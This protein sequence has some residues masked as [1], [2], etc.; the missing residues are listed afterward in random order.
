MN[1][2]ALG[3]VALLCAAPV[4][5]EEA[6]DGAPGNFPV[7]GQVTLLEGKGRAVR[8]ADEGRGAEEALKVGASV[9]VGDHLETASGVRLKVTL[10]DKSVL[11]LDERSLLSID[12]ADFEAQTKE[13][14]GFWANLGFGRVWAR[15]SKAVAGSDAKFEVRT[16]R[17]V[18]GVRGTIF[19]V[20]A[21]TVVKGAKKSQRTRVQVSEGKVLVAS[22]SPVK[23]A[24]AK[25]KPGARVQV[26][27]PTEITKDEWEQRF[28]ELQRGMVV[29]VDEE[30]WTE[31]LEAPEPDH[32]FARFVRKNA[33]E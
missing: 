16:E 15:V 11:M 28:L 23:K 8:R 7:V 20:D 33:Q 2:R 21:V 19:W 4:W 30:L 1:A 27:G 3:L 31:N 32:A 13:R 29:T 14:K 9:R 26:Q 24:P 10:N 22:T 18:A 12:K 6:Q 17:A 25:V 5:A